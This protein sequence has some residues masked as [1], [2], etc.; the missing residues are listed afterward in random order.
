[1]LVVISPYSAVP[2]GAPDPGAVPA[3]VAV[4]PFADVAAPPAGVVAPVPHVPGGCV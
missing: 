1:M 2:H 3:G 4:A